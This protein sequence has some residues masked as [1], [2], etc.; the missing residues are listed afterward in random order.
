MKQA[1][2]VPND[3]CC[4]GAQSIPRRCKLV[5]SARHFVCI[6]F[7]NVDTIL[8][9]SFSILCACKKFMCCEELFSKHPI[10]S[11]YAYVWKNTC[12]CLFMRRSSKKVAARSMHICFLI[13]SPLM[14]KLLC[15]LK[16]CKY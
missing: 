12:N 5:V 2:C 1:S 3:T 14:W 15:K 13:F 11:L 7:L 10:H 16:H 4:K 8:C 6:F 9:K